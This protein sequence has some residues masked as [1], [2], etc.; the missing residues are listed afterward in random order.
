RAKPDIAAFDGVSI[1]NAGGF[2]RCPPFC[3]FFG[4]SAA[5][6]HSAAV[7]ALLLSK[8]PFLTPPD[9]QDALRATAVDIGSAGP[10]DDS[11]AGRLDALA[12]ADAI[13]PPECAHDGDCSDGNVCRTD[14]C[15]RGACQHARV[16]DGTTCNDGNACTRTDTCRR[17]ACTGGDPVVCDDD[18]EPCTDD[19][20]DPQRG[21]L[22][23]P[24]TGVRSVTCWLDGIEEALGAASASDIRA[25][26]RRGIGTAVMDLTSRIQLTAEAARAGDSKRES[27]MLHSAR[28]SFKRLERVT[29][30]AR[31]KHRMTRSLALLIRDRLRRAMA[32]LILLQKDDALGAPSGS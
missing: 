28:R 14:A 5:A 26:V 15:E 32:E 17:G 4:T 18:H 7:A 22:H 27:R 10:D 20:C 2:P 21:C 12:A 16:P 23:P 19:A 25:P 13:Q 29:T 6:P 11:G 31:H 30:G 24:L 3:R 1:S 9:I 8:N